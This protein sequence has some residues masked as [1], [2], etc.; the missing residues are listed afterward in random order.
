MGTRIGSENQVAVSMMLH[1]LADAYFSKLLCKICFD[2]AEVYRKGQVIEH[3]VVF[4]CIQV[5][6]M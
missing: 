1:D 3:F 5:M 2:S 4:D 6:K